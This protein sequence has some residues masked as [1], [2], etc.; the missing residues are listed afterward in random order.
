MKSGLEQIPRFIKKPFW[1]DRFIWIAAGNVV[2]W[3][4]VLWLIFS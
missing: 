2:F 4:V 3:I 1:T